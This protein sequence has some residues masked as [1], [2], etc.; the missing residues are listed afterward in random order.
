MQ[1][2]NAS[3]RN[4]GLRRLARGEATAF[5]GAVWRGEMTVNDAVETISVRPTERNRL[6]EFATMN[7]GDLE[8]EIHRVIRLRDLALDEFQTLLTSGNRRSKLTA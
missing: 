1:T 6:E 8:K 5:I 7:G 3:R 4:A 2:T